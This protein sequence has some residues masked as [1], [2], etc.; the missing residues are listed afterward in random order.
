[1]KLYKKISAAALVA[2]CCIICLTACGGNGTRLIFTTGF[3]KNE[4][5]RIGDASCTKAELMV[6]LTN[7]QNQYESVYGDE[8][9]KLTRDGVT[10]E[11]NVKETVL[12]KVAQI[13][14]M[15]LLAKEKGISLDEAETERVSA[16]AEE[17]FA[18]LNET[19]IAELGI[20]LETIETMYREYALANKVYR[21][22][23]RDINPEISDDEA[24]TITVQHIFL[25]TSNVDNEGN[26]VSVSEAEKQAL[27][28][29]MQKIREEAIE[30]ENKFADLASRYSDDENVTYSFGKG[31]ME[32]AF[33]TAAFQLETGEISEIVESASGYHIIKC[34]STFDREE[35]DANKLEIVEQ[36]RKEVFGQE[37]DRFVET[38]VRNLNTKLWDE[39]TL[40][41]DSNIKTAD[42]FDVCS[43]YF[44][45]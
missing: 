44:P 14:T 40:L 1:M 22:I 23:I 27:Y 4:V 45:E 43:K 20:D 9:W 17:Y 30:N 18:S 12:A 38:L 36:R 25:R 28:Q 3:D 19:E 6:C 29:K 26:V 11:Q 42:F 24:R 41:H 32:E 15:Y 13:K 34:L 16:A 31:D 37:Y 10:L 5:F 8:V 21:E 33:E 35:T 2:A 39:I 7:T